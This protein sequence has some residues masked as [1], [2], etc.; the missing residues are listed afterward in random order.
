VRHL[1]A[2]DLDDVADKIAGPYDPA[3]RG[4]TMTG[5]GPLNLST[6]MPVDYATTVRRKKA[7]TTKVK[8]GLLG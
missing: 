4:T 5:T 6:T 8:V 3:Y 7:V 2:D 1:F